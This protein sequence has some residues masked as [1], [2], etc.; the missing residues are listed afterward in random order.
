MA[1][2]LIHRDTAQELR[3]PNRRAAEQYADR[4]GGGLDRWIVELACSD[5]PLHRVRRAVP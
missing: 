4:F 3:F 2:K 5:V 1:Y